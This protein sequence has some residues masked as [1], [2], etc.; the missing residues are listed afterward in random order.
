[1]STL[2][3]QVGSVVWHEQVSGDPERAQSFYTE[4]L[5][6]E[7]ENWKPGEADYPIIKANGQTHG[8]F[9][10]AQGD[11]PAGWIAN[12]VVDDVDEA[13]A[14]AE[15]LGGTIVSGPTE[16]AEIGRWAIIADPQGGVI[17]A[18]KPEGEYDV[19]A[20]TFVW[21]ELLATDVDVA[22]RFYTEVFGW[23]T[24]DWDM[25]QP[26]SYTVFNRSAD[27]GAAGLAQKPPGS[28]GGAL[29][30][31]YVATED[32]DATTA[33]A[34]ELG[35]TPLM[36]PYDVENVGRISMLVDPTGATFGLLKP[37]AEMTQG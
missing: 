14:R 5:G 21:D 22:K 36:E 19:P 3:T 15:S 27:I 30:M 33:R 18:Y 9:T 13:A 32:V 23:T 29:W 7:V 31:P 35:A 16:M 2:E 12:V 37:S 8:G 26:G 34:K 11:G 20:G 4:L 17:S 6:W 25:G 24:A 28:P 10:R 1:M